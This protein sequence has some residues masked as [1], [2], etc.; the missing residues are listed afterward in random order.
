M[1]SAKDSRSGER[2][3]DGE[4]VHECSSISAHGTSG[5]RQNDRRCATALQIDAV[6]GGYASRLCKPT[7]AARGR[8]TDRAVG[9]NVG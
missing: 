8:F 2:A 1:G 6:A 3:L 5:C 4:C 7:P 9:T